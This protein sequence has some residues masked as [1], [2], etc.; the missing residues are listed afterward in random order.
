MKTKLA[1]LVGSAKRALHS[2]AAKRISLSIPALAGM[3]FLALGAAWIYLP[4][5][6]LVA[7]ALLLRV[8]AQ[9]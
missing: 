2:A 8:D 3:A 4:A 6:L 7:G 1:K 5:G 9:L